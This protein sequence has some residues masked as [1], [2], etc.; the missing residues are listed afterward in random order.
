MG[1]VILSMHLNLK[2][3]GARTFEAPRDP[4]IRSPVRAQARR[5]RQQPPMSADTFLLHGGS[6]SLRAALALALVAGAVT[7]QSGR[8]NN[9]FP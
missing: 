5:G 9:A 4:S 3:R 2:S 8:A 1:G 7:A 6:F